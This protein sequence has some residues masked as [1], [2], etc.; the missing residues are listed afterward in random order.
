MWLAFDDL[1]LLVLYTAS[2]AVYFHIPVFFFFFIL[3]FHKGA[4][5]NN[6]SVKRKQL[7]LH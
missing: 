7:S 2:Y 3:K 5:I 6:E 4:C 1:R